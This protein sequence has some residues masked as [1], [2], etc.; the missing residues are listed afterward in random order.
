MEY[1]TT[2]SLLPIKEYGRNVYLMAQHLLTIADKEE[3]TKAANT[4]VEVMAQ[5]NQTSK[6]AFIDF[7]HKLWDHLYM[8]CDYKLDI[9][10]PYPAPPKPLGQDRPEALP[11][12]KTNIR[13]KH[14]GKILEKMIEKALEMA[15]GPERTRFVE[16]NANMM[17]HLYRNWNKSIINDEEVLND[18][19]TLS[20]GR[21]VMT[22]DE[23]Q[24]E[25]LRDLSPRDLATEGQHR[26]N[27]KKKPNNNRNFY[28]K[29][30]R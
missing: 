15:E 20:K 25:V 10:G 13:I 12:P 4:V 17:K 16:Q 9:E 19:K 2:R 26:N 27:K 18:L 1:N 21:I 8:M 3:R 23:V 28:R 24:L 14:Y 7:R 5:L 11:Y 6:D 29:R 30:P 22:T